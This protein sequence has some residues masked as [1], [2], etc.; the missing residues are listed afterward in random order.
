[1]SK[2]T[3]DRVEIECPPELRELLRTRGVPDELIDRALA[4][5]IAVRNFWGWANWRKLDPADI[6]RQLVWHQRFTT[7]DLRAR[8][9][10]EAD[11]DAFC[12]LWENSPEDI[13]DLEIT[14]LRGPDAFAQFRLQKNVHLQVIADGNVLVASCGWSRRNVLIAGERHSVRYGQALRTHKDYRRQGLGD[15]VRMISGAMNEV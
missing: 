3:R 7:G 15:A 9:V 8:E 2:R 6:E 5:G 4:A 10:T 11:N 1:M 12:D 14:V 13:G